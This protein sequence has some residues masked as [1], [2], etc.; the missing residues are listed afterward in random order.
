MGKYNLDK[1]TMRGQ[2]QKG[3]EKREGL[4]CKKLR[5]NRQEMTEIYG[6]DGEK[7][8]GACLCICCMWA[9]GVSGRA[10]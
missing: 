6:Q 5:K 4:K 3:W 1:H 9:C 10:G 8:R 7:V 2:R